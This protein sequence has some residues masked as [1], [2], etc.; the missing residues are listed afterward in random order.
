MQPVDVTVAVRNQRGDRTAPADASISLPSSEHGAA[1][2]PR[3]P[4]DLERDAVKTFESHVQL[5]ENSPQRRGCS[6]A[7]MADCAVLV[8]R[9]NPR[10]RCM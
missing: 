3:V 8:D 7:R 4:G 2:L 1:I 10:Q 9:L 6:H 5:L